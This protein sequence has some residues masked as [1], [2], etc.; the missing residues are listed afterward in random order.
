VVHMGRAVNFG[1]K[2][3][4]GAIELFKHVTPPEERLSKINDTSRLLSQAAKTSLIKSVA[5]AIPTYIMP[6]FPFP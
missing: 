6:L 4:V 3:N 1:S 2:G 5:N